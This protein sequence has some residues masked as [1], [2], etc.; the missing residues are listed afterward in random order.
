MSKHLINPDK[1]TACT[2]CVAHCPVTAAT[3][4]FRGPKMVGP[5]LERMRLSQQDEDPSLEYCS[6]C[7]NCDISCPS[8]VPI[9][10][11]NMLA[12]AK[13]FESN[14]QSLRDNILSHGEQMAKLSSAIPGMSAI[15]NLGM[16]IGRKS[17]MLELVGISGK[18]PLPSYAGE[19]F[20]KQFKKL[21]QENFPDKVVF[22]PGCFINYNDPQV[23]MD[24]VA[25]MQ[26]NKIEVVIDEEFVC[27]GSPL[28]VNGYLTE[29]HDN[30]QKNTDIITKWIEKGYPIITCC[31]SCGLML[32][33]EY[34]ELFALDAVKTNAKYM[35]DS[36]EFLTILKDDG[37]LNKSFTKFD[38]KYIY[39]APC[40][41]RAQGFGLPALEVLR[42]IPGLTIE[43][44]DAGC[45]GIAGSYGLKA[46]KYDISMSIGKNLFDRIIATGVD[47]AVCDCGTC[48]LQI[49]HG[50]KVKTIHPISLL[51]KAYS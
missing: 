39:H 49:G 11:L 23:G 2:S 16:A 43:D 40:H 12:R 46:D 14:K 1:C 22:F 5:A 31:T 38:S 17:G 34:Q 42:L 9:S 44:A 3:R 41:L 6:N 37:R 13:H 48:R 21:R 45:C 47:T 32:K 26:K 35:Y 29:A 4:K 30:A 36:L 50:A 20:I 19:S 51:S 18:A 27:C 8:G 28:V 15:T 25:V 7:K 10:T 33:Q 24:F